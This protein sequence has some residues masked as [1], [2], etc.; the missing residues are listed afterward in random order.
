MKTLTLMHLTSNYDYSK[1][2]FTPV[3]RANL[4]QRIYYRGLLPVHHLN[5]NFM[6]SNFQT[7]THAQRLE[8]YQCKCLEN[9]V[10]P[11]NYPDNLWNEFQRD[12]KDAEFE[13]RQEDE[14]EYC[15][16]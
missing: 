7:P 14:R 8:V 2:G 3:A 4:H 9:G 5:N 1:G 11:F 13:A 10:R 6:F 12:F 16:S 15:L